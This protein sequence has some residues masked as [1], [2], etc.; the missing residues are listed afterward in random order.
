ML[1]NQKQVKM[2]PIIQAKGSLNFPINYNNKY[3]CLY[4]ITICEWSDLKV[5]DIVQ[6]KI[7]SRHYCY[8]E[9]IDIRSLTLDEVILQGLHYLDA[10]F[11][12]KEYRELWKRIKSNKNLVILYFKKVI[13]LKLF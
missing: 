12:E 5:N 8:C 7:N 1:I 4:N 3:N 6:I 13:Q 11:N 2:E 9:I 10:G